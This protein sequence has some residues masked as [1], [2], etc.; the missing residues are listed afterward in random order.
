MS[1]KTTPIG[2][3]DLPS[4]I[5][6][7]IIS[8]LL[9]RS[10]VIECEAAK[11]TEYKQFVPLSLYGPSHPPN[12]PSLPLQQRRNS[13][14]IL[15]V[16]RTFHADGIRYLY[17]LRTFTLTVWPWE[18]DFLH[19]ATS[20]KP[21]LPRLPYHLLKTFT[22]QI[23]E[24]DLAVHGPRVRRNLVWLCGLLTRNA[25][26][27]KTLTVEFLTRERVAER[28]AW[29]R[30]WDAEDADSPIKAHTFAESEKNGDWEAY[31]QGFP[32]TLSWL[33]SAFALLPGVAD[34]CTVILPE[35]V[36]QKPHMRALATWYAE[37]MD[38]RYAFPD[39]EDDDCC[40][41]A[42][43]EAFE[44]EYGHPEG[45]DEE[46]CGCGVCENTIALRDAVLVPLPE[47][48][49]EVL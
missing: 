38:G 33:C 23:P 12:F 22:I 25:I 35:S 16:N 46:G 26:H 28:S 4:E 34:A 27:V 8:Y 3:T 13:T 5:R 9:L 37:G 48:V 31:N 36:A 21:D 20:L 1:S 32:S 10:P 44:W 39:D 17:A 14:A 40:A 49:G 29:A 47:V 11:S 19:Q 15:R 45:V 30:A 18:Y 43:R 24:C 42:D 41:R 2:L 6:T 7:H